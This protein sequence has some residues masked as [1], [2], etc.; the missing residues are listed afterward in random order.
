[1][2][3]SFALLGGFAIGARFALLLQQREREMLASIAVCLVSMLCSLVCIAVL[4][5]LH[6]RR[7]GLLLQAE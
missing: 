6:S 3:P 5:T 4:H 1:M 7:C 2:P